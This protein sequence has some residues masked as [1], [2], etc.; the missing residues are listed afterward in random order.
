MTT[1]KP[2]EATCFMAGNSFR[3]RETIQ[4]HCEINFVSLND[5]T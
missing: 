3:I 2:E 1:K 4:I 5:S